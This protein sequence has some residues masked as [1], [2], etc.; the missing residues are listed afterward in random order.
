MSFLHRT[1]KTKSAPIFGWRLKGPPLARESTQ[2][3]EPPVENKKIPCKFPANLL[4]LFK[5]VLS[6]SAAKV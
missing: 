2:G 3:R 4:N 1:S 5:M 6:Q